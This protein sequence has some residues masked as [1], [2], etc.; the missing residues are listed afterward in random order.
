MVLH[1]KDPR[2]WNW[3]KSTLTNVM[4]L[5]INGFALVYLSSRILCFSFLGHFCVHKWFHL[6]VYIYNLA[7]ILFLQFLLYFQF[8]L[9][10]FLSFFCIYFLP[11]ASRVSILSIGQLQLGCLIVI[12]RSSSPS[13]TIGGTREKFMP[14]IKQSK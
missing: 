9:L 5:I 12:V 13:S 4:D 11:W 10:S 1:R 7:F 14:S 3:T 6:Y 8:I 2:H